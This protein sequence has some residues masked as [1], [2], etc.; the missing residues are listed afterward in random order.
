MVDSGADPKHADKPF[1]W[2][3]AAIEKLKNASPSQVL[4]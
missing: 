4:R 3:D 1:Q 2:I